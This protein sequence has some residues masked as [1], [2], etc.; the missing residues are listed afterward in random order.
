MNYWE[1]ALE[2][3]QISDELF[4]VG[5]RK[6]PSHLLNTSDG[7]VL[8]DTGYPQ[9]LYMLLENIRKLSFDYH[10]VKHIIHTHGHIDHFGG[11]RALVEM[12]GAK[13]YIGKGDEDSVM[14]KNDLSYCVDYNRELEEPFTPDVVIGDGDKLKFGNKEIDFIATP[15]HTKGTLS[16]FMDLAWQGKTYKAG[17]FGGAGLN[18]LEEDYIKRHNLSYSCRDEYK[19]SINKLLTYK[20]D[21]HLGN[22][23]RDNN[24]LVKMEQKRGDNNPFIDYDSWNTFLNKQKEKIKTLFNI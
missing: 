14:G 13:T 11:T 12:C 16:I 3:V 8:I 24:H 9:S 4:Y 20:V 5:T 7:L 17:M 23:V 15:G 22:H 6:G 2:P 1:W 18:T 10:D 21:I 19:A